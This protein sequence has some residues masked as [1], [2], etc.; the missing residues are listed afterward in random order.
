MIKTLKKVAL[1]VGITLVAVSC[2]DL[3]VVNPN[4]PDAERATAQPVTTESFVA[5]SFRTWWPVAGHDDYPSWAF[6]TMAREITSGFADFGQLELSAEPRQAWNNSPVNGR[7]E[8]NQ[9]PWYAFYRT[10]SAASDVVGAIDGG[11]VIENAARTARAKAMGKF[12]QGVSY[13]YLGLYYDKAALVDEKT[14]LDT[15]AG[16]VPTF[17]DYKAVTTFAIAQLDAA[18]TTANAQP[19]ITFPADGWM[20]QAMTKDQ[21]V[22]LAN[23]FAARLMVY[24]ARTREERAAVNWTEVIR[25]IDAGIQTDF[26]PIAQP[27]I[28]FDDWKRLIARLRTAGRPSDFGRPSYWLVGPADSTNGWVNWVATPNDSR[29]PFRMTTKDRRIQGTT[30]PTSPGKYM[31]YNLNNIFQ[32]ARGTYRWS[33]YYYKRNG[34]D[35]T[36]QTGPQPAMTVTEMDLLKAEGLIRLG[37]AAEAVP[38]INKSRVANG[39]LPPVTVDGPPNEAGCVPRK[40]NG[41]CGSLWD[42][43]R[44]EKGVEGVGVSGVVAFFDARGWRTLPEGTP[45]HFPIPGRELQTLQLPLY[46]FGGPGGQASAPARDPERCPVAGLARCPS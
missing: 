30:G 33:H 13:G 23:S 16:K 2:Q 4:R 9:N 22:R 8:V 19:T 37:R 42:A 15:L 34:V 21:F 25:R 24:S 14:Q 45:L 46:T 36:W 44:Y 18:I 43:L 6:A 26:A 29:Q 1:P 39:E 5:S 17:S 35:L 20:Y 12:M 32:A 41:S 3:D 31:G 40:E 7:R 27:D 10:I 38:L 28:L 11:L